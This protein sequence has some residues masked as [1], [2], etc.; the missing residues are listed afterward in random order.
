M[1]SKTP[2]KIIYKSLS[3][4]SVAAMIISYTANKSILWMLIHGFFSW[5][6]VIYYAIKYQ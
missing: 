3:Y 4:G 2:E 1:N 5:V 6:Y